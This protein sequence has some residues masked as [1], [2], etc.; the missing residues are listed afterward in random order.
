LVPVWHEA[1]F[2]LPFMFGGS[3]MASAGAAA[4]ATPVRHAG[5]ARGLT[6]TGAVV[7]GVASQVMQHR[8]GDLAAPYHSGTCGRLSQVAKTLTTAG[9]LT[10][11]LGGRRDRRLAICGGA[12]TLAAALLER[13][14]VFRAGVQGSRARSRE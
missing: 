12:A 3:A 4:I 6:L 2:E 1:R 7:E 10:T 8:L 11:W 14:A 5:P 9:A 13:C